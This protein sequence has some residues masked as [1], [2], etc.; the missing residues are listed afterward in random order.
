[1]KLKIDQEF[2]KLLWPLS[3]EEY[4]QLEDSLSLEG[5]R[6]SVVV[7]RKKPNECDD[8]ESPIGFTVELESIHTG[9]ESHLNENQ[10]KCDSCGAWQFDA[11]E[12]IVDGHNRYEI[13]TRLGIPFEVHRMFFDDRDA[14]ADWIDKNQAGRRNATPD[15]LRIIRGRMYNRSKKTADDGGKGTPKGTVGQI[16]PRFTADKLAEQ[17]KVSPATIKRDGQLAEA[18]EALGITQEYTSGEITASPSEIVE[19]ANPVVESIRDGKRWER[20]TER[21]PLTPPEK[22]VAIAPEA[23]EEI[24]SQLKVP[25]VARNAGDNEWYTPPAFIEA[26]I[27]V[28]GEIDLD[29][30]SSEI[31]NKTVCANVF[32]T[33]EQDGLSQDWPIGR[34]WMNP[35]YSQPLISRFCT[36]IVDEVSRGSNAIVL[37]NNGTETQWFQ[38]MAEE[39]SAVCFPRSRVRFLDPKGNPGAPLQGQAIVYFGKKKSLFM[40]TFS[41]FGE[42]FSHG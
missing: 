25:H 22:P 21:M 19:A 1:M 7:W 8:C 10:W 26:A 38:S 20:D 11:D 12:I 30:A 40:K 5:C 32:Y 37:V 42:V 17:F 18:V 41:Q 27:E 28:F 14:V 31:A 29:P 23:I 33:A 15:Q 39:C 24:R 16:E 9:G 2:Q 3:A 35:P 13:C 6:D 34:I 4:T 36:R